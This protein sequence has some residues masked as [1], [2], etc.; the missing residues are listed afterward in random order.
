LWSF[1]LHEQTH[2]LQ[3]ETPQLFVGLYTDVFGL[4]QAKVPLP[5]S[6]RARSIIDPD[7]PIAE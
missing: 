4:H 6:V 3:R 1:L 2:V 7:A 5:D